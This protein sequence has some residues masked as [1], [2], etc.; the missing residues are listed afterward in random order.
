MGFT[1]VD[2][3]AI[4]NVMRFDENGKI[5]EFWNHRHDVELPPPPSDRRD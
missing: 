3:V 4:I 5:V 1:R 2:R